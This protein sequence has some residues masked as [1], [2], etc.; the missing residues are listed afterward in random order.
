MKR[1][2]LI[3][4]IAAAAGCGR[5]DAGMETK[6]FVIARLTQEEALQ[7]L[8]PY[9]REGGYLSGKNHLITVREKPDR[10]AIIGDLL[11]KYD[12]GGVVQ[13]VV[14]RI[15]IV[16]A[17]GFTA[18]DSSI[19]D[20]EQTLREMFKYKG[21]RLAGEALVRAREESPFEQEVTGYKISG[22]VGRMLSERGPIMI[23]LWDKAGARQLLSS[24]VTATMNKPVVLGQSSDGGA[25]ILIIRPSI[26]GT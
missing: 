9:I 4:A 19:A 13:D 26:A 20:I 24:T 25:I 18:R 17:N 5:R 22:R 23:T 12:G 16:E 2:L 6:T 8:T 15:Q 3:L 21:Y 7:L 10:V 14:M 11:K 1:I